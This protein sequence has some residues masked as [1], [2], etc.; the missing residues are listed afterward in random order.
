VLGERSSLLVEAGTG[1]GK[2]HLYQVPAF[3]SNLRVIVATGTKTLQDQLFYKDVPLALQAIGGGG[4]A[5]LL[6]V[7]SIY[8]CP[9]RL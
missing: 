5:A 7:R 9:H 2:T 6:K 3:A 8:L 1:T 4:R